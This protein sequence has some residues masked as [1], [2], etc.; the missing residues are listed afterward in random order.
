MPL[1]RY[2]PPT[3][4]LHCDISA[5]AIINGLALF[6]PPNAGPHHFHP[7]NFMN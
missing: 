4:P 3:I 2:Q 5:A 6:S 7:H 1:F